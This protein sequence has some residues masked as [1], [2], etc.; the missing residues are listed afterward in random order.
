MEVSDENI[1]EKIGFPNA[2]YLKDP[3]KK[4]EK[5][6]SLLK[7]YKRKIKELTTS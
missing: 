2:K 7:Y 6:E 3:K 1:G 4:K 5:K